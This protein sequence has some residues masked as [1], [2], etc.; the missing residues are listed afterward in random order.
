[1]FSYVIQLL[2]LGDPTFGCTSSPSRNNLCQIVAMTDRIPTEHASFG[3][4]LNKK[5]DSST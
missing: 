5:R 4:G 3:C 1:M 2:Y